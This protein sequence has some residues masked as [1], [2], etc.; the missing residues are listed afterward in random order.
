MNMYL[1]RW[2]SRGTEFSDSDDEK[3]RIKQVNLLNLLIIV[4]VLLVS[5]YIYAA[6]RIFQIP[7]LL[8]IPF[9][10]LGLWLNQTGKFHTARLVSLLAVIVSTYPAVL[11]SSA[12]T[13]A[14]LANII[15]AFTG[16]Y[17]LTRKVQKIALTIFALATYLVTEYYSLKY[18]PFDE[19]QYY[20]TIAFLIFSYIA[21]A[22]VDQEREKNKKTILRQNEKLEE[23]SNRKPLSSRIR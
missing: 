21:I 7:V 4:M 19:P 22:F 23:K 2:I 17:L 10:I 16:Y 5:T 8:L 6:D 13:P 1:T 12:Q 9:M 18:L 14:P 20:P 15:I 3:I 11:K